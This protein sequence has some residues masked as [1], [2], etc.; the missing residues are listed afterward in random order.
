MVQILIIKNYQKIR[1][2]NINRK[3][4]YTNISSAVTLISV[5]QFLTF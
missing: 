3:L 5:V 4:M 2:K 1:K